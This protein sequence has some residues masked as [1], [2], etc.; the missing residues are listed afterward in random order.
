MALLN[1]DQRHAIEETVR[2]IEKIETAIEADFQ[3]HFVRAMAFPHKTD[4]YPFLSAAVSLPPRDLS[5]NVASKDNPRRRR[6]GRRNL[7]TA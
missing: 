6:G 2:H 4:P 1:T 3:N 7:N 5:D